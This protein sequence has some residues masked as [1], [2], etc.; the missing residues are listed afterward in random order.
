MTTFEFRLRFKIPP[1]SF[2]SEDADRITLDIPPPF[3]QLRLLSRPSNSLK[4]TTLYDAIAGG[5]PSLETAVACGQKARSAIL[6][7]CALLGIGVEIGNHEEFFNTTEVKIS[8][9]NGQKYI[10]PTGLNGLIAYPQDSEIEYTD[11]NI[12]SKSGTYSKEFKR[13]LIKSFELSNNLNNRIG[14]AFEIYNSH[15]F[16][17][18]IRARFLQLVSVIECLSE[19]QRHHKDIIDHLEN[20][21]RLSEKK[22]LALQKIP[23]D[24]RKFFLQRLNNLK[25][26]SIGSAC[27]NLI[28]KYLDEEEA[29]HFKECYNIRSKLLHTGTISPQIDFHNHYFKLGSITKK[30]LYKII[31]NNITT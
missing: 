3:T 4:N 6:I 13:V 17:I 18:S 20:L 14:L 19:P 10:Q 15:Y 12:S 26:E 2:I 27:R 23:A 7:C 5:F 9:L 30:L 1:T 25:R 21:V 11:I 29:T 22:L 31:S 28:R 24:D 8:D 16:E